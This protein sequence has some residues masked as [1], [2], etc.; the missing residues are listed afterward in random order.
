[1]SDMAEKPVR[2]RKSVP[3]KQAVPP[4][5][6]MGVW[7]NVTF[8]VRLTEGLHSELFTGFEGPRILVDLKPLEMPSQAVKG[9][10]GR[11]KN[12]I[13]LNGG[14]K[15]LPIIKG[16]PLEECSLALP[17]MIY[18]IRSA[19]MHGVV[20]ERVG[21]GSGRIL[22]MDARRFTTWAEENNAKIYYRQAG[23]VYENY[24]AY[25]E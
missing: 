2:R 15:P 7:V 1:M 6:S 20:M 22:K 12:R 16:K 9:G 11:T 19:R 21:I 8:Q 4:C 25:F 10:L 24:A 17:T 13:S 3:V 18:Q 14:Y 23:S 5:Q